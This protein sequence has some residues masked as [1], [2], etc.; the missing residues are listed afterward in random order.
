MNTL[1]LGT[2]AG[3]AGKSSTIITCKYEQER[4]EIY[5]QFHPFERHPVLIKWHCPLNSYTKIRIVE[6]E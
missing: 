3:F 5:L 2:S 6:F 1:A 4:G